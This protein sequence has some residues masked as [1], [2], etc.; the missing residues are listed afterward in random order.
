MADRLGELE[1]ARLAQAQRGLV[2]ELGDQRP[3]QSVERTA[4][5][6]PL[7]ILLLG[8]GAAVAA[9]RWW[10]SGRGR[11][12]PPAVP[13]PPSRTDGRRLEAELRRSDR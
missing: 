8:A 1:R 9:V 2:Q 5:I 11:G 13:P 6:V 3:S 10:A 12:A 4:Y 7:L